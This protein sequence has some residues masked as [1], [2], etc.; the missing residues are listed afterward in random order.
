MAEQ[1][2][3]ETGQFFDQFFDCSEE[4]CGA[5]VEVNYAKKKQRKKVAVQT[6]GTGQFSDQFFD[7]AEEVC[8]VHI[9]DQYAKR[10][11]QKQTCV[12]EPIGNTDVYCDSMKGTKGFKPFLHVPVRVQNPVK[13]FV[14]HGLVD[15]EHPVVLYLSQL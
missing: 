12:C 8:G 3:G 6:G 14:L 11:P 9:E 10:K 2:G 13:D 15:T 4:V 7:C 5:H 1:T